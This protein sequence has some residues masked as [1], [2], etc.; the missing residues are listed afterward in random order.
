M[1]ITPYDES[2]PNVEIVTDWLHWET[3]K[4]FIE[5]EVRRMLGYG[6]EVFI[7]EREGMYAIRHKGFIPM[8]QEEY[9]KMLKTKGLKGNQRT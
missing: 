1:N 5:K 4:G 3:D 6:I 2:I 7:V 8:T 9:D